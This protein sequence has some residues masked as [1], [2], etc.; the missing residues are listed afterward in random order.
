[1]VNDYEKVKVIVDKYGGNHDS[2][3]AILQDVQSEYHYLPEHTLRAVASQL[4]LPLI[5]VCGVATFFKAFSLKPRGEHT[6]T[7]C[8]G[9]ACHVR[10]APAV[11]DEARRQL[12]IEPG[13]TTDDMRFT[14]E[15]VNCLGACALGPI[16]VVDGEYHGQMS[17]GKVKKVLNKFKKTPGD[18]RHEELEVSS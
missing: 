7:I 15:T 12:G 8:L 1:M 13:N 14:L 10:G 9:T 2:V 4:G 3:I 17:P 18:K 5:Q 6:V 11:L 16:L